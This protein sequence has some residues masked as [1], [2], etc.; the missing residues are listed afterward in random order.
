[1]KV[2]ELIDLL[3]TFPQDIEVSAD[4]GQSFLALVVPEGVVLNKA[5][6]FPPFY[7]DYRVEK[8]ED[9][10]AW[11]PGDHVSIIGGNQ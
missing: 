6:E 11:Y 10:S 9:G 8:K 2:S 7:A 3:K 4:N 5:G 1:M